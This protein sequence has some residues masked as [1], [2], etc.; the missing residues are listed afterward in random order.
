M[1][2]KTVNTTFSLNGSNY[3][4]SNMEL[5]PGLELYKALATL[6]GNR[7]Q[8]A[9]QIARVIVTYAGIAQIAEAKHLNPTDLARQWISAGANSAAA[10]SARAKLPQIQQEAMGQVDQLLTSLDITPQSFIG[11]VP[12]GS[13]LAAASNVAMGAATVGGFVADVVDAGVDG[14]INTGGRMWDL[15]VTMKSEGWK[16]ITN[17]SS[18]GT[19]L[20]NA[21][22]YGAA[23]VALRY[24]AEQARHNKPLFHLNPLDDI[25]SQF[26]SN[27]IEY[28][29]AGTQW[30]YQWIVQNIPGAEY[31]IAAFH[32]LTT[33]SD[34]KPEWEHFLSEARNE[35]AEA[36][37]KTP[38]NLAGF[39]TFAD[40]QMRSKEGEQI[41]PTLIAAKEIAGISTTNGSAT[42][43]TAQN[44]VHY[45]DK[46]NNTH[47]LKGGVG[48]TDT[49]I[50][51]PPSRIAEAARAVVGDGPVPVQAVRVGFGGLSIF[52][53]A[54]NLGKGL[55]RGLTSAIDV[56]AAASPM[57]TRVV[58][59]AKTP[60][61][62]MTINGVNAAE[63]LGKWRFLANIPGTAS[64]IAGNVTGQAI[65]WTSQGVSGA[66]IGAS[67]GVGIAA[68]ASEIPALGN[69][70]TFTRWIGSA[71]P[72]VAGIATPVVTSV[73]TLENI[74]QGK[75]GDAWI[76]GGETAA[77]IAT[78]ARFGAARS[79][80]YASPII[81]GGEFAVA[82]V[83]GDKRGMVTS[84]S[85]LASIGAFTGGGFLV[86]GPPG[87]F[88]GLI[89]GGISTLV[90]GPISGAIYDAGGIEGALVPG[91]DKV[92]PVDRKLETPQQLEFYTATFDKLDKMFRTNSYPKSMS[93]P[94]KAL[95]AAHK[96]M[97]D[98]NIEA[99][100][101]DGKSPQRAVLEAKVD[102]KGRALND[103]YKKYL[104]QDPSVLQQVRAE[105]G[106]PDP[107]VKA[108]PA[109]EE[110]ATPAEKPS[111]Q[112]ESP[113]A[114][115]T[116]SLGLSDAALLAA[117]DGVIGQARLSIA[118]AAP[119]KLTDGK[120]AGIA[121]QNVSNV[122][123][124]ALNA[125]DASTIVADAAEVTR[126]QRVAAGANV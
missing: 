115:K 96:T 67:E 119:L 83:N 42:V 7:Q 47:E 69:V 37:Q 27:P 114:P 93:E 1:A 29:I 84:G 10:K 124:G 33:W 50:S 94:L 45:N 66:T 25:H 24:N 39:M 62:G 117:T 85:N 87:A 61:M 60:V 56:D 64:L 75:T 81:N 5:A 53:V 3:D 88:G 122:N 38:A 16:K 74:G 108:K 70:G 28:G 82:A 4:I 12:G 20:E 59:W 89:V 35:I 11:M 76:H 90:V 65:T 55:V 126:R 79:V 107:T 95:V 77:L 8:E 26:G 102:Q 30:G 73:Q 36:R 97:M 113:A 15:L 80:P 123:L 100:S 22:V 109:K 44:T 58:S 105:L 116:A 68:A 92:T 19:P 120:L 40:N 118:Q 86:G 121:F 6:P 9:D 104:G 52:T 43:V 51:T 14:A 13:T 98:A 46:Q 41:R 71:L 31:V 99:E 112:N 103:L 111:A 32:W 17:L 34:N 49:I 57:L 23:L 21:K 18:K 48:G 125:D 2:N 91:M 106:I 63:K 110:P 101:L 78:A 72:K 54:N